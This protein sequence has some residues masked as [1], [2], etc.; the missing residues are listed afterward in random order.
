MS[1][2]DSD[3]PLTNRELAVLDLMTK[4]L[5]S[6]AIAHRLGISARTVGKHIENIYRKLGT[7]DRVS[8]VLRHRS[9]F[10]TDPKIGA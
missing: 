2:P 1:D 8:T 7:N 9:E 10:S 5:I 4:G 6:T 3:L